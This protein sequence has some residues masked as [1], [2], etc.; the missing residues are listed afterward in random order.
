MRSMAALG[1]LGRVKFLQVTRVVKKEVR[2]ENWLGI[3]WSSRSGGSKFKPGANGSGRNSGSNWVFVKGNRDNG[4]DSGSKSGSFG[5][6]NEKT[7]QGE[8]K[9][10]W[11]RDRGFTHLSYQEFMDRKQKG[12]CFKYGGLFHPMHQC[13]NK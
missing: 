3:S 1:G 9:K 13:P 12:L 7:S 10:F 4:S 5:P 6:K 11:P 2:G 8:K